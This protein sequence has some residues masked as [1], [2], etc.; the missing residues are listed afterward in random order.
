MCFILFLLLLLFLIIVPYVS[1]TCLHSL[2]P[3]DLELLL[4]RANDLVEFRIDAVLQ[5]MSGATLCALPEEE[6]VTAEEF[7]QTTKVR[8]FEC[9]MINMRELKSNNK[10]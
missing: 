5:E 1:D 6:P 8:T 4:D 7:V 2:Y 3:E 10:Y 9:C